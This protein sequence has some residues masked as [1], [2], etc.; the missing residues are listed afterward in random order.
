MEMNKNNS[1]MIESIVWT[2]IV[3]VFISGQTNGAQYFLVKTSEKFSQNKLMTLLGAELVKFDG[4]GVSVFYMRHG[5]SSQAAFCLANTAGKDEPNTILGKYS[6]NDLLALNTFDIE[7]C[8]F[9]KLDGRRETCEAFYS[10]EDIKH[11][12]MPGFTSDDY[13]HYN[14]GKY[15]WELLDGLKYWCPNEH[16]R[17]AV[18]EI[19][20]KL[21]LEEEEKAK[22][23][24][25]EEEESK[26]NQSGKKST[27]IDSIKSVMH[28]KK[29]TDKE[30][31]SMGPFKLDGSLEE[32]HKE[33]SS[34]LKS[35]NKYSKRDK[36]SSMF[37]RLMHRVKHHSH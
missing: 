3:L 17:L 14:L 37:Q 26:N 15:C 7:D 19:R 36:D 12:P 18:E 34:L 35:L 8:T 2:A 29:H 20:E 28:R 30:E 21:R 27:M 6:I 24:Q 4:S 32:F 31:P 22:R 5:V 10:E 9:D 16:E 33:R 25:E 11:L 23:L 1:K 13:V